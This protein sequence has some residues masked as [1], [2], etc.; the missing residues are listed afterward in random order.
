MTC[1]FLW[2]TCVLILWRNAWTPAPTS[3]APVLSALATA[4]PPS[5][6][7]WSDLGPRLSDWFDASLSRRRGVGWWVAIALVLYLGIGGLIEVGS[8]RGGLFIQ[9]EVWAVTDFFGIP[10]LQEAPTRLWWTFGLPWSLLVAGAAW[11]V[12]AAAGAFDPG[13]L[14][15]LRLPVIVL[16]GLLLLWTAHIAWQIHTLWTAE[17]EISRVR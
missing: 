17:E 14:R 8:L 3:A 7:F 6:R 9:N 11:G 2:I 15:V 12:A 13:R 4:L 5:V 16:G 10:M 1:L